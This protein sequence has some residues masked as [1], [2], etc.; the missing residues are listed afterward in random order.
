MKIK[1]FELLM[2]VNQKS[3]KIAILWEWGGMI[4]TDYQ[5]KLSCS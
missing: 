1:T 4:D 2:L 3:E 5:W